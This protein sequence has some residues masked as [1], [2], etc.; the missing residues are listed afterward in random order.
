MSNITIKTGLRLKQAR[1]QAGYRTAKEFYEKFQLKPSTYTAHE[2]GRNPLNHKTARKYAQLLNV[3]ESWLLAGIEPEE[4][5]KYV[6]HYGEVPRDN[7]LNKMLNE[8]T[9][10]YLKASGIQKGMDVAEF[11]CGTGSMACWIAEYIGESNT[12]YAIDKGFEQLSVTKRRA[13]GLKIKN[14]EFIRTEISSKEPPIDQKVDLIYM[15]CFL[16][17][18]KKPKDVLEMAIDLLPQGGI[19]LCME[20][21]LG[22][23]WSYPEIP[24]MQKAIDLYIRLGKSIGV[25]FDIGKKLFNYLFETN[26]LSNFKTF[27]YHGVGISK[28]EKSWI[29]MITS[30]CAARYVDEKFVTEKEMDSIISKISNHISQE[31]AIATLPEFVCVS[32]IKK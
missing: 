20:P 7:L 1:V 17:H 6:L 12:I 4:L 26:K 21:I 10:N 15:R 19:I 32:G 9:T 2:A 23:F 5:E 13:S 31:N 14:I 24:E 22:S 30:E 27:I 28:L 8:A 11:G 25:D 16:H 18:L 29:E 3:S